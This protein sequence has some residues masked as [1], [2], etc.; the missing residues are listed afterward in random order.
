MVAVERQRQK[1]VDDQPHRGGQQRDPQT[2]DD[3]RAVHQLV[4]NGAELGQAEIPVVGKGF[5]EHAD[6]RDTLKQQH[7]QPQGHQQQAAAAGAFQLLQHTVKRSH[8]P[9]RGM[10]SSSQRVA[11]SVQAAVTASL[12]VRG[13]VLVYSSSGIILAESS[14]G[15]STSLRMGRA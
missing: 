1:E 10:I 12:S 4:G 7:D 9:I 8:Q 15:S 11:I 6:Q 14:A 3:G 13:M 5:H 2:V